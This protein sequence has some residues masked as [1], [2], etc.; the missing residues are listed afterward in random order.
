[1]TV[2]S[3]AL[4][5]SQ[6]V[7]EYHNDDRRQGVNIDTTL[8]PGN[9]NSSSFGYKGQFQTDARVY[10]QPLY[11]ANVNI[12]PGQY[13]LAAP[14]TYN[15]V[16]V[17]SENNTVYAFNADQP[18]SGP[19]WKR[20]DL[21]YPFPAQS[22]CDHLGALSGITSTPVID[23]ST[24]TLYVVAHTGAQDGTAAW[25]VVHAI[26]IQTGNDKYPAYTLPT[27]GIGPANK[28]FDARNE[29]QRAGLAFGH[30]N[31]FVAFA[32]WCGEDPPSIQPAYGF[33]FQLSTSP[34]SFVP[35]SAFDPEP[36]DAGGG[37]WMGGG[38]PSFDAYG[39]LY[40]TVSNCGYG[41][42]ASCGGSSYN[43]SVVKISPS[44][45]NVWQ[46]QDPGWS[47]LSSHDLDV[48]S[49]DVVIFDLPNSATPFAATAGKEGKVYLLNRDQI[50]NGGSE[51]ISLT[52]NTPQQ[53]VPSIFGGIAYF[54]S[55]LYFMRAGGVDSPNCP[56]CPNG[57][58]QSYALGSDGSI[59]ATYQTTTQFQ[60]EGGAPSISASNLSNSDDSGIVWVIGKEP[61]LNHSLYAFK[62]SDLSFLY[63]S[64]QGQLGN[65]P[66]FSVPTV[67]AGKVFAS[68]Y[69]QTNGAD[70]SW[71]VAVYGPQ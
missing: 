15:V 70:S 31:L 20:W 35:S 66:Q 48:G 61:G 6:N 58:L 11:M 29:I 26:D 39:N 46:Y 19:L 65:S 34:F 30:G 23:Q 25:F 38:A 62:A 2:L 63:S 67:A 53:Q 12:N 42:D 45:T 54:N 64:P 36:N 18:N 41:D 47:Y 17:A 4:L 59:Q 7:L 27:T 43:D 40:F 52:P 60:P 13:V 69:M 5:H 55:Q 51:L 44:W 1:M 57:Y 22:G 56:T 21:G 50:G 33:L 24:N 10:A 8:N 68:F 16:F 37:I 49:S 71:G 3:P 32:D 9:V 28:S 14:G